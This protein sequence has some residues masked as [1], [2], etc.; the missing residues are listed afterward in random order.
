M[1]KVIN[2][3]PVKT[4]F[5]AYDTLI[6]NVEEGPFGTSTTTVSLLDS[7]DDDDDWGQIISGNF[8]SLPANH[9]AFNPSSYCDAV[10][11]QL[12]KQGVIKKSVIEDLHSGFNSYP[13]Y[14]LTAKALN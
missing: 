6:V 9:F 11:P 2:I 8:T 1:Q 10:L 7:H 5:N 14:E 4:E 12:E 13:V 3:Q